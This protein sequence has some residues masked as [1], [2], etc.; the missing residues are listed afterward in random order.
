MFFS[1]CLHSLTT[2][3]S[4]SCVLV[5]SSLFPSVVHA[6]VR[7]NES[8]LC[9]GADFYNYKPLKEAVKIWEEEN[10]VKLYRRSSWS[11]DSLGYCDKESP[12]ENLQ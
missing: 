1:V 10:Y 2:L 9:I 8:K 12:H 4:D 7:N 3:L 5:V 11:L 6:P